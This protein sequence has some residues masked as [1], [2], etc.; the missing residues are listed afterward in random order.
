MV[1]LALHLLIFD[2]AVPSPHILARLVGD[3]AL[4]PPALIEE[5]RL[6]PQPPPRPS[7][8]PPGPPQAAEPS[9][10]RGAGPVLVGTLAYAGAAAVSGLLIIPNVRICFDQCTKQTHDELAYYGVLLHLVLSPLLATLAV[11]WASPDATGGVEGAFLLA[12]LANLAGTFLV[13]VVTVGFWL[14][15]GALAVAAFGIATLAAGV[16]TSWVASRALEYRPSPPAE[17]LPASRAR[18]ESPALPALPAPS[19][20]VLPLLS[21]TW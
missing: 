9:A 15:G 5:A 21:G 1:A 12:A 14:V 16:A 20:R 18:P 11:Y 7:P 3:L 8:T 6:Q 17:P 2:A 4:E 19:A 10:G 13:L